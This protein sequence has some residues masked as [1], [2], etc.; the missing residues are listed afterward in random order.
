M[1]IM[2]VF[3]SYIYVYTEDK[4][5]SDDAVGPLFPSHQVTSCFFLPA[6]KC[7]VGYGKRPW[8]W[9]RTT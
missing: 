9:Q 2:I 7:L 4:S 6:R 5:V 8:F 3:F 1:K